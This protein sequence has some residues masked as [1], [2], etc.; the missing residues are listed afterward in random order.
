[1]FKNSRRK[2]QAI[3]ESYKQ[4]KQDYFDFERIS[5]Y[6]SGVDHSGAKQVIDHQVLNDLDFEELFTALDR[7]VS[8]V[9]QQ[10]LYARLRLIPMETTQV[11]ARE[12]YIKFLERNVG[13]K[14]FAVLELSEL[15]KPGTYFLQR[16]FFGTNL[17]K[18]RW[19]WLVPILSGMSMELF[20]F[21]FSFR[22]YG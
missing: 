22:L 7:T 17:E 6:F 20:S 12:A 3:L 2:K 5:L 13:E 16:L 11:E 9:G 1:M 21:Q 4:V 8:A 14:E 15:N 19:F 18:P 10:Y